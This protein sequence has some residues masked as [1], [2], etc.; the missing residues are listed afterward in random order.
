MSIRLEPLVTVADLEAM[1]DDSNRYEI[2]A[3]ELFLSAAP[4]IVH[5]L[6]SGDLI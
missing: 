1:P 2:V 3:G 6:V 4:G 5:Q